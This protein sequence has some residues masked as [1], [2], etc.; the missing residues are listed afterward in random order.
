MTNND[1][2][3]FKE[4]TANKPVN[5]ETKSTNLGLEVARLH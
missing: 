3:T 2:S 4:K 1:E 5:K